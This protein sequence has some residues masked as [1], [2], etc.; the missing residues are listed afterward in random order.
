MGHG[1]GYRMVFVSIYEH[2]S[3]VFIFASASSDQFP[4]AS[5]EHF[6]NYKWQAAST[7]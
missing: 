3:S 4:H 5:S 6:R 7:L 1:E 2:A